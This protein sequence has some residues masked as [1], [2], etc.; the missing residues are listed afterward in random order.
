MTMSKNSW[1]AVAAA[2]VLSVAVTFAII[3]FKAP[4]AKSLGS[5]LTSLPT[6]VPSSPA[7][8]DKLYQDESGFSFKYPADLTV[9]DDTPDD[10]VY[11]SRLKI[12]NPD[13]TMLELSVKDISFDSVDSWSRQE[14][15]SSSPAGSLDFA[16]MPAKQFRVNGRLVTAAVAGKILYHLQSPDTG[17]WQKIHR[18]IAASFVEGVIPVESTSATGQS[19]ASDTIYEPE[20]IVE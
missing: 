2:F 13:G 10:Q 20:E 11:S 6:P 16:K 3:K 15:K 9:S 7:A 4:A 17:Y 5:P 18:Q 14:L 1:I 19:P 8:A 12:K